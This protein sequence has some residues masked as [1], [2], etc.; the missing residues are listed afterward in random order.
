M[1]RSLLPWKPA[2]TTLRN[3][4]WMLSVANNQLAVHACS[5]NSIFLSVVF[6]ALGF[7]VVLVPHDHAEQ[8]THSLMRPWCCSA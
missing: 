4:C 6:G 7:G 2:T 3:V 5:G 8:I 1:G